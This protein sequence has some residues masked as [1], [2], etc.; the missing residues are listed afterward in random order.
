MAGAL[1]GRVNPATYT[2]AD[3]PSYGTLQGN[4]GG[5]G[6]STTDAVIEDP[7]IVDPAAE[8]PGINTMV[9]AGGGTPSPTPGLTT[10]LLGGL[11]ASGAPR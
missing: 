10:L 7:P 11:L 8:Q 4:C 1:D 5:A 3:C 9:R 2:A 6:A